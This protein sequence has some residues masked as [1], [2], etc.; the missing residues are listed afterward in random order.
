MLPAFP[1]QPKTSGCALHFQGSRQVLW[2]RGAQALWGGSLHRHRKEGLPTP[3]PGEDSTGRPSVSRRTLAH[4]CP[5]EESSRQRKSSLEEGA[6]LAPRSMH[7]GGGR[8]EGVTWP[9]GPRTGPGSSEAPHPSPVLGIDP[10]PTVSW[11]AAVFK[12][13]DLREQ[14]TETIGGYT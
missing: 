3:P 8:G 12:D 1:A 5:E 4:S 13:A 6:E 2:L 10:I 7:V 11:V 9:A 14:R